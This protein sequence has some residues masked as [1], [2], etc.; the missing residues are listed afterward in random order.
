MSVFGGIGNNAIQLPI[1][2][3]KKLKAKYYLHIQ[4]ISTYFTDIT[5]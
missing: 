3:F 5:E 2:I 1:F 4:K